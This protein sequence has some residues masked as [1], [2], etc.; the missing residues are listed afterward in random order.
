MFKV[1]ITEELDT[2]NQCLSIL[3]IEHKNIVNIGL[4]SQLSL[5]VCYRWR[6]VDIFY[7]PAHSLQTYKRAAVCSRISLLSMI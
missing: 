2:G 1:N 6:S 4:V 5:P 7:L 3:H